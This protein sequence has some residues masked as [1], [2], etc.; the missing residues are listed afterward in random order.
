ML[1][2]SSKAVYNVHFVPAGLS[3]G[4]RSAGLALS[5]IW[6]RA[7]AASHPTQTRVSAHACEPR[8]T[9]ANPMQKFQWKQTDWLTDCRKVSHVC[10]MK[11]CIHLI[12]DMSK[13]ISV[14]TL[15]NWRDVYFIYIN[16]VMCATN[17]VALGII[18]PGSAWWNHN[19]H[20]NCHQV[21]NATSFELKS[22]ATL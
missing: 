2:I 13:L 15:L 6:K 17:P 8:A 20:W 22:D 5:A 4:R 19:Q 9:G 18:P 14:A 12:N 16:R 11:C 7:H 1:H 10:K 21:E 3:A